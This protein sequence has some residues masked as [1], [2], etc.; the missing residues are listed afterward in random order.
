MIIDDNHEIGP[1]TMAIMHHPDA[2][3]QT[4]VIDLEGEFLTSKSPEEL[5]NELCLKN[6]TTYEGSR[7]AVILVHGYE[8]RTPIVLSPLLGICAFP[9][10]SPQHFDCVWL[11]PQHILQYLSHPTNKNHSLVKFYNGSELVVKARATFLK[12]QCERTS[13]CAM[14]IQGFQTF[15]LFKPYKEFIYS[16]EIKHE[17]EF[18]FPIVRKPIWSGHKG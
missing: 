5:L 16:R 10:S 6:G 17:G 2:T 7:Q 12:N 13:A 8:K 4:R 9:T 18:S 3:Y 1:T 15:Y 11:F 14:K